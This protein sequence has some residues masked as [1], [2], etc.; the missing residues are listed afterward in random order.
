[1]DEA[2]VQS[3]MRDVSQALSS[4][5]REIRLSHNTPFDNIERNKFLLINIP[6]RYIRTAHYFR[7]EYKLS[8][9]ISD[10]IQINNIAYSLQISDLHNYFINRFNLFGVIKNL[11]LKNSIINLFSIEEAILYSTASS[12][13]DFCSYNGKLCYYHEKCGFYIRRRNQLTFYS[14][15]ETYKNKIGFHHDKFR[16]LM[17]KL[18]EIRDYIHISDVQ[19]SELVEKDKYSLDQYN[20]SMAVLRY[21]RRQLPKLVIEFKSRRNA[22]C[23][24]NI[25]Y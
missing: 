16:E 14:L 1:M 22:N 17:F 25:N 3:F 5:E 8:D 18:K 12:L 13:N 23:K 15:I 24:R 11:Y 21:T 10:E 20:N 7:T 2:K 6:D 4:L 19:Y 9:L